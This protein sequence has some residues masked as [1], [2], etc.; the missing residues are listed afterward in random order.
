M[1]K[2][3][4][5]DLVRVSCCR[6]EQTVVCGIRS[7]AWCFQIKFKMLQIVRYRALY[8]DKKKCSFWLNSNRLLVMKIKENRGT[9]LAKFSDNY[10]N[11]I[12]FM[13]SFYFLWLEWA[14]KDLWFVFYDFRSL[15]LSSFGLEC[16]D[17]LSVSS[18]LSS[19]FRLSIMTFKKMMT[20]T[21]IN[22]RIIEKH[23]NL[24]YKV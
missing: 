15:T 11:S 18:L 12:A 8:D 17:C 14:T 5:C 21:V 9:T 20:Q 2:S 19:I 13:M 24:W 1:L 6:R 4:A 7:V 3:I 22:W 16:I 10:A 23:L